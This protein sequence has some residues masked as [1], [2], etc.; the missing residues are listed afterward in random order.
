VKFSIVTISFNQ[1]R[2]L[3]ETLDSIRVSPPHELQ[4]VIVDPG[5][6]D[7]ARQRIE[8]N[9]HLFH[10][11]I[12]E[13]D[14]GPADGLNKGFAAC[15]GD[16]Y[17]YVNSDDTLT[18]HALDSV[19]R[20][21]EQHPETDVLFGAVRMV[22]ADGHPVL[23]GRTPDRFD[24]RR[25]ADGLCYVWNPSTFI[26]R[27]AF[28]KAGGFRVE[29][30]VHWDG[31]LVLDLALT[32]ARMAYTNQVFGTY[33]LHDSSVTVS[34]RRPGD[35]F[36]EKSYRQRMRVRERIQ[37]AG[38]PLYSPLQRNMLRLLYKFNPARQVRYLRAQLCDRL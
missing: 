37:S 34:I 22:D 18:P 29:N 27:E 7:G 3:Q 12:L 5:S 20:Y 32:G 25:Y 21:F 4:Y 35:E 30:R 8:R 9:R 28:L 24:L 23:R 26:R 2:F 15:D 16:I 31:E 11:I 36:G 13:N 33:R 14:Q 19:A 10:R 6:T 17:A 1:D 38:I